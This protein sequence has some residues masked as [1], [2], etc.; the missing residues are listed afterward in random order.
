[1]ALSQIKDGT[2][3]HSFIKNLKRTAC[4]IQWFGIGTYY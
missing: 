4:K 1:M 3:A 2:K